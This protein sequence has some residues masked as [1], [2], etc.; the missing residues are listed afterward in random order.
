[1]G[2]SLV[3]NYL[4]I[5]F[6]TKHRQKLIQPPY[7]NELHNYLGGICGNLECQPLIVGGYT[8]HIH[9]Y[10][11]IFNGHMEFATNFIHPAVGIIWDA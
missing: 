9:V 11:F 4:H 5:T 7:E 3:K 10:N 8:D 6:S 2:Q 1:M